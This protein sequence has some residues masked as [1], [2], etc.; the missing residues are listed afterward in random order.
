MGEVPVCVNMGRRMSHNNAR[1][2]LECFRSPRERKTADLFHHSGCLVVAGTHSTPIA[3]MM[4]M[5]SLVAV[6]GSN[7]QQQQ[8]LLQ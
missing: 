4:M 6:V 7:Q 5:M 2:L 1:T 8:Q 3:L